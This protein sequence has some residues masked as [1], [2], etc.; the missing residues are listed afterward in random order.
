[1]LCLATT[2]FSLVC[3]HPLFGVD[4]KP[5]NYHSL[6]MR[7][8]GTIARKEAKEAIFALPRDASLGAVGSVVAPVQAAVKLAKGSRQSSLEAL[9]RVGATFWRPVAGVCLGAAG[10]IECSGRALSSASKAVHHAVLYKFAKWHEA[11]YSPPTV[12]ERRKVMEPL[13][14]DRTRRYYRHRS[15]VA[16]RRERERVLWSKGLIDRNTPRK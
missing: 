16:Q 4:P 11:V 9:D 5:A 8:F 7:M 3:S 1:M 2:T 13:M 14:A 10:T 12:S 6:S 15:R